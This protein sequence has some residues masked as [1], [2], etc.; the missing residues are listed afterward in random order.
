MKTNRFNLPSFAPWLVLILSFVATFFGWQAVRDDDVSDTEVKFQAEVAEHVTAIEHRMLAYEQILRAG[1]AFINSSD[2]VTRQEWKTFADNLRVQKNYPGTLGY[3][4]SIFVPHDEV[5]AHEARMQAEGFSNYRIRSIDPEL[6]PTAIIY[7][8]PMNSRNRE[9]IG[10]NMFKEPN[11]LAAMTRAVE[12][13]NAALAGRVTLVQ[14]NK[15]PVQAGTLMYLPVYKKGAS[16]ETVANRW[17][18]I[19][20]VVYAPLRMGDLMA[21]ILGDRQSF[22]DLHIFDGDSMDESNLMHDSDGVLNHSE[23]SELH[24]T[25]VVEIAGRKWTLDFHST[26]QFVATLDHTRP[27]MVAIGGTFGSL[28]L[29]GFVHGLTRARSRAVELAEQMT[30]ELR[31]SEAQKTA[32]LDTAVNA[33]VTMGAD[34]LIRTFNPAAEKLF[35]YTAAE[36]IGQNVKMLMPEPYHTEH[37]GYVARHIETGERRIIGHGREVVGRRKDGSTF[38]LWLSVGSAMLGKER[39]FVWCIVDITERRKADEEI[40]KLS[41]AVEQSP[42]VVIITDTDGNI[43]YTNPRFTEVTGY[44]AAEVLGR[45]PRLLKTGHTPSEGY[46][47]IWQTLLAGVIWRGEMLNR[48]KN[49]DLYWAAVAIAPIRDK[50]GVITGFVSLQEDITVRKEAEAQLVAAKEAAEE[51]NRAKSD[52]LNTMSHELR[53]P[54]TVILGYLP[55]IIAARDKIPA[56]KKLAALLAEQPEALTEFE[57][58]AGQISKMTGEV[59]K[60]GDHLLVLINDILDLSKIEAGKLTLSRENLPA[61]RVVQSVI[62][63]LRDRAEAKGLHLTGEAGEEQIFADEVRLKQIF[64]NLVGNAVKF[65]ETGEIRITTRQLDK[66]VEFAVTDTGPGIPPNQLEAIFDRFTQVDNTSTRKA[67]GTGLG[68]TITRQLVTLHGGTVRV[69]SEEGVGSSFIFTI[70]LAEKGV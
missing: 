68:L 32:I 65:T 4:Y 64:L 3:A 1:V 54:L 6:L 21:G 19:I 11:R 2:E 48:K 20:G 39:L 46:A 18:A 67:G 41:L 43:I 15:G 53:T 16:L 47:T 58:F 51:S 10:Y 9:A 33:I 27:W 34:R 40:R 5:A 8:E 63:A 42:S 17:S 59:K 23:E 55:L 35:G 12:T 25:E 7:I 30:V 38:P 28:L 22:I 57:K 45:N 36:V 37:D 31:T 50:S 26:P 60:N 52:F 70:P 61:S 13:G 14:E 29:F 56:G 62:D 49:D 24:R 44:T 69:E 66:F